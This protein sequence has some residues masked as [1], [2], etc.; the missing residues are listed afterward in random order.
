MTIIEA[1]SQRKAIIASDV[2]GDYELVSE[3]NGCLLENNVDTACNA[4]KEILTNDA[5]RTQMEAKSYEKYNSDFPLQK[6]WTSY[7]AIYEK[8][9]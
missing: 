4:I 2:G 9:L 1:M 3:E 7:K 8:L 5:L 6:M